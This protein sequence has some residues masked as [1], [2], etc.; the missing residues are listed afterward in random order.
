MSPD[1]GSGR[2]PRGEVPARAPGEQL[3]DAILRSAPEL[4]ALEVAERTGLDP[5]LIRDTAEKAD[6]TKK[7]AELIAMSQQAGAKAA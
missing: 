2:R 7:A 3:D 1:R 6:L 5:R 4:N